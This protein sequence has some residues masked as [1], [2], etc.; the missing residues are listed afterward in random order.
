LNPEVQTLIATM[1]S[2]N[3]HWGTDSIRGELLQL[4][5]A[6]SAGSIRRYRRRV[7]AGPPSQSWRTFL[8]NHAQAIWAA[9]L[10]VVQTLTSSVVDSSTGYGFGWHRPPALHCC[11]E[12]PHRSSPARL[13]TSARLIVRPVSSPA[14]FLFCDPGCAWRESN[15][16]PCG[17]EVGQPNLGLLRVFRC[18][19]LRVAVRV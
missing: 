11:R 16:L 5:I 15:P 18:V 7:P 3:P 8:A 2:E 13:G 10:F 9:D 12:K 1:A 14:G 17:P 4:G 19:L 6:V